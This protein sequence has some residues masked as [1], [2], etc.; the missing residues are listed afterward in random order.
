LLSLAC[1]LAAGVLLTAAHLGVATVRSDEPAGDTVGAIDGETISVQGPLSVDTVNGRVKTVLRSGSDVRV[2]S[3][4]ARIDL[5]EG[6][7]ITICGPA[8][9]SVLKSGGSLTVALDS[10]IIRARVEREPTLTVYTAQIQAKFLAIGGR[11]QDALVGFDVAGDL[12]IRT[13]TGA[14]RLENQLSG[15]S[16]VVP[17][18]GDIL[19]PNGQLENLRNSTGKCS[20]EPRIAKAIPVSAPAPEPSVEISRPATAEE[21]HKKESEMISPAAEKPAVKEEPVYR[22]LMPPLS[23]DATA[24]VQRNDF[25]P[26][27]ILLVR[28]ARVRPT[29]IFH[30]RVEGDPVVA[31][32]SAPAPKEPTD[33][34][35]LPPAQIP[36]QAVPK[37]DSSLYG[38]VRAFF[39]RLFS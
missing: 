13:T 20:C 10:G 17:E 18:G 19:V 35:A 16:I 15:Q 21:I 23:Y 33:S 11:A 32:T 25:D 1:V 9:F 7:Q 30:G 5:V 38:R 3:G 4:Q 22:V 39:H 34:T 14:L 24:K 8:H 29:L 31:Q 26:Q 37:A 2:K 28:R 36:S 27:F 12:C 6:G